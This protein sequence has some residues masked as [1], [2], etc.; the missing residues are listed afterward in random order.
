MPLGPQGGEQ[1]EGFDYGLSRNINN[2][3]LDLAKLIF[4]RMGLD[5]F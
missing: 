1:L 3:E 2:N 4:G 5:M